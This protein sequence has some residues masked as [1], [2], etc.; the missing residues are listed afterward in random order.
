MSKLIRCFLSFLTFLTFYISS[1]LN[2]CLCLCLFSEQEDDHCFIIQ[3][4][5]DQ[6]REGLIMQNLI[7]F[8]CSRDICSVKEE[9]R[10]DYS[11]IVNLRTNINKVRVLQE[12]SFCWGFAEVFALKYSKLQRFFGDGSTPRKKDTVSELTENNALWWLIDTWEIQKGPDKIAYIQHLWRTI[13]SGIFG[14]VV[15]LLMWRWRRQKP[16]NLEQHT[17]Q[18]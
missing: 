12:K 15:I 2:V 13:L 11:L 14:V 17:V 8:S 6:C 7:I 18:G 10:R 3:D 4:I 5:E 1:V 9:A 16:G